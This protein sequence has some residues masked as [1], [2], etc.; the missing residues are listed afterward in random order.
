MTQREFIT[1]LSAVEKMKCNTRHCFKTNGEKESVADHSWRLSLMPLL[2]KEEFPDTDICRVT[3]MCII[4]DL[5]EAVTGDIPCF[6]KTGAD[7]NTETDAVGTL[8]DMLPA[9]VRA[10]FSAL[11]DEMA[12]L[13]TKEAKLWKALDNMEAVLAHNESDLKTW[14]P[15][16]YELNVTYGEKTVAFSDWLVKLK[17]ELNADTRKKI[18]EG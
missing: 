12:S 8:L 14:L 2:L 17:A 13:E 3:E 15:L 7:E 6:L 1:F 4:H 18:D 11:Y 10:R 16:E 9:D 5:G